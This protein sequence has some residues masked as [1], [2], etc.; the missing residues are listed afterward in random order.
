MYTN[1]KR[2]LFRMCLLLLSVGLA[3][4]VTGCGVETPEPGEQTV[5]SDTTDASVPSEATETERTE[6]TETLTEEPTE[7]PT[8][9]P[10]EV[11]T[12]VQTEPET[13]PETE[14]ETEAET[15]LHDLLLSDANITAAGTTLAVI[16][17][18][19]GC[20]TEQGGYFDGRYWYQAFILRDYEENEK[21]NQ[22][23]I[24]KWDMET[25]EAV[26]ISEALPLNHANDITYNAKRNVLLVVHNNPNR[27]K[28]SLVDPDSLELIETVTLPCKIY[29]I[30]YNEARDQYVVGR[31]G[32]QSFCILHA[33][34]T[35]ASET[36]EPTPDT[37][38]YT[39]QGCTSDDRFIY[40]VLY[41]Q[42]C[43]TVYD[44]DGTFIRTIRLSVNG[45]PEN[46][47][48]IGNKLYVGI[49][50][51]GATLAEVRLRVR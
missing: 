29:C 49:A 48:V 32:G 30:S 19:Y 10:T 2:G 17:E 38:G 1:G 27:T 3:V 31:S 24:V 34:F 50:G 6:D 15:T 18:P 41:N 44:W 13:V 47:S 12:E 33:D 36:F 16:P 11:P 39:T 26:K 37:K 5:V 42:N 9:V 51:A 14:S 40:F 7:A 25:G 28:V 35:M 20:T 22:V 8:S 21:N 23:R 4:A 43:I 45:E 46:I